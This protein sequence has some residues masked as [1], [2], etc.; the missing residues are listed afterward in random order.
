ML[1]NFVSVTND[2][3]E[4]NNC[5]KPEKDLGVEERERKRERERER[6]RNARIPRVL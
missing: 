6:E 3:L 2:I 5:L 1:G 4:A